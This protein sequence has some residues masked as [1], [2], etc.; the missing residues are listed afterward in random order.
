MSSL[1]GPH[2]CLGLAGSVAEM[3]FRYLNG[4]C[5]AA[6]GT[7]TAADL[8]AARTHVLGSFANGFSFFESTYQRCMDA[9]GPTTP[10]HFGRENLLATLLLSC[11]QKA[12]RPAFPNQVQRFGDPW[13]HQ[14]FGGVAEYI[15]QKVCPTADDRLVKIYA[16]VS[17]K[18]GA[19]LTV[20]DLMR[21]SNVKRLLVECVMP[22]ISA[23][24]PEDVAMQVS[25][26]ASDFIAK[27]RGIP[28]PDISKV[29]E[30]ETRNFLTWLPPQLQMALN[31][32]RSA[33]AAKA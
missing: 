14:F 31:A 15:R 28:K 4:R 24:A 3:V 22:L 1:R 8:D 7:L 19:K 26:V 10:A 16:E 2:H 6:G 12:A 17:S 29:T 30:Q 27:Q 5:Q 33:E 18:L 21:E 11:A 20:S 13:L 25:D 9:C 32:G 23:D